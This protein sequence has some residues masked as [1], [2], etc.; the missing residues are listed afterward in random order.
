M[1]LLARLF[2][3]KDQKC[4]LAIPLSARR[5][6]DTITWAFTKDGDYSVKT[7]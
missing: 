1:D 5:L 4:I 7:A 2:N 3:E 6:K